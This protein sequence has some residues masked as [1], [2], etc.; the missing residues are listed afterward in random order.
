MNAENTLIRQMARESLQGKWGLAI[1][2][3]VLYIL[4]AIAIQAVPKIGTFISLIISGPLALG[5]TI[6][7]LSISR[8][9]DAKTEQLF[10]GFNKFGTAAGA[11]LLT[12]LFSLLWGLLLIVPGIIAA[13]SYSM[14]FYILADDDSI[15]AMDAIDK[16]KKMMDGYKWK[17]FRLILVFFG[18]ALL[19]ILTLGIGFLWLLPYIQVSNA[20][21]YDDLKGN[22]AS[23]E[24]V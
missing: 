22:F 18:L 15:S 2:T 16:S 8:N 1:G 7:S 3:N 13:I 24:T 6:F 23:A 17:Y 10:Q 20:K 5:L 4:A 9:Q 12:I 21:F 19:C 14:T 11:Y